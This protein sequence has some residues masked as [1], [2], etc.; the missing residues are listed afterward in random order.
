MLTALARGLVVVAALLGSLAAAWYARLSYEQAER[1]NEH[2]TASFRSPP[3]LRSPGCSTRVA[4]AGL[5]VDGV[6][7]LVRGE[8]LWLLIQAPGAGR[9]Y[10]PSGQPVDVAP[11]HSWSQTISDIGST[12]DA[13][14]RFAIV[15]VAA[16]LD[17]ANTFARTFSAPSETGDGAFVEALPAGAHAVAQACVTRM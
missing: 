2:T 5:Q 10:I 8:Q 6:A 14:R 13:D 4:Q 11:D 1:A 15:A 16:N 17:A 7:S 12:D 9:F 3:T